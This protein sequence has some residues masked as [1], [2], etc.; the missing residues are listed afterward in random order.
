MKDIY[1]EIERLIAAGETVATATVVRTQGST[2]REV[3]AKMVVLP[4]GDTLGS[5]GGGSGEAA[6]RQLAM[7]A[8][9]DG[10]RRTMRLDL[11]DDVTLDTEMVCGG[12][13]SVFIDLWAERDLELL[14]ALK[15]GFG[16]SQKAAV[17]TP[18]STT[19]TRARRLILPNGH[20]FGT[21]GDE[22]IDA[23]ITSQ[24]LEALEQGTSRT[25][26][27][28]TKG[29]EVF[30]E[31]QIP[32]PTLIIAGAGHIAV[33]LAKLGS[34]L[35][36]RVVVLDDRPDFANRERFPEADEVLAA[37]FGETLSAY[38]IDDQ[39]YITIMTRGHSH[40]LECL[41]QVI[42]S[43]AAYIGMVGSRRRVRGVFDLAQTEGCAEESLARVHAPIGL[44]IGARTPE[45]IA[46]S[47]MAEVAKAR[48]GGN[49][50]SLSQR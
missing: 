20:T 26:V 18:I 50:S 10:E 45:E 28:P 14:A 48:G 24:A 7:S 12:M 47:I 3:G 29:V 38:P 22:E 1:V 31:V 42:E 41:L 4:S 6:V 40:D 21:L 8:I 16:P 39:T 25:V 35:G 5:I 2:P 32:P 17:A 37:D 11:T 23:W 49:G 34:M 33:P 36:F 30:I 15:R 19:Q 27:G 44:D 46:L 43:P 13:M 9:A